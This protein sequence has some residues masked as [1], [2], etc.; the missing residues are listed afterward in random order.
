MTSSVFLKC[1]LLKPW[2]RIL[3]QGNESCLS[4]VVLNVGACT[5]KQL[6][7]ERLDFQVLGGTGGTWFSSS[8]CVSRM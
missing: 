5:K 2:A 1:S 8:L 3:I 4:Y 7:K 6:W